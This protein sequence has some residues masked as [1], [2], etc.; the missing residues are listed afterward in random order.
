MSLAFK[1]KF[2]DKKVTKEQMRKWC[3]RP[4]K[5][6]KA[7][8]NVYVTEQAH[9]ELCDVNNIIKKYDTQGVITHVS[10]M[11]AK[12]GDMTGMDFKSMMDQITDAQNMFND[13]PSEIRNRFDNSPV[14]L[15][16]FMDN[17]EN[18]KEAIE[19]G[20]I[21]EIWTPETDG[22]GEHV[23]LG[24]NVEKEVPGNEPVDPKKK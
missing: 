9:K 19:L 8:N 14:K 11:E 15:L 21:K 7:G 6:D 12:F 1:E 5:K 4:G 10:K 2:G 22:L 17:P 23:K 3:Q 13:L 20:M 18:R 24:E 16:D